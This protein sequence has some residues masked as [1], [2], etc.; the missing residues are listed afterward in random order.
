MDRKA[1][2]ASVATVIAVLVVAGA[3]KMSNSTASDKENLQRQRAAAGMPDPAQMQ[4]RMLDDLAQQLG[5]S[6]DQKEKIKAVQDDM[7]PKMRPDFRD[8]SQSREQMFATMRKNREEMDARIKAV[9]T[10]EQQT[11]Y[12]ALEKERRERMMTIRGGMRGEPGGMMPGGLPPGGPG[13]PGGMPGGG[14]PPGDMMMPPPG[15]PPPGGGPG[16]PPGGGAPPGNNG[17]I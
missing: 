16:G 2:I 12:V 6:A 14:P 8:R 15:G 5:L 1:I 7:M 10:P 17:P 11:K 4:A 13:G 9:L 3:W